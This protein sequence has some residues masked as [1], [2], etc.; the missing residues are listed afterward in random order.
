LPE[1]SKNKPEKVFSA[2][3]NPLLAILSPKAR[4]CFG[5]QKLWTGNAYA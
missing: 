3:I 2:L 5:Q 1:F 4:G